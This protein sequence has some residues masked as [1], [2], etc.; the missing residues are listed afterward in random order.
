[1]EDSYLCSVELSTGPY[2]APQYSSSYHPILLGIC[3]YHTFNG[4]FF[5]AGNIRTMAVLDLESKRHYWL[6]VFAQDHGVVP[7]HSRLEVFIAVQNENDN[8]PLT[9]EPVYYPS[10]PE[11]SPAGKVVVELKAED[12]DLD[13]TQRLTFRITAGNPGGF[14]SISPDTG[15]KTTLL[16]IL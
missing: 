16:L 11:N 4:Y 15:K 12:Y 1:P 2:P 9:V 3:V 10:I 13:P 8:T 7:L 6:T 14:F 5:V